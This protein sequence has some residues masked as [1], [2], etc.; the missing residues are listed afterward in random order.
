MH[1]NGRPN[2]V[3]GYQPKPIHILAKKMPNFSTYKQLLHFFCT[4]WQSV[5]FVDPYNW[6]RVILPLIINSFAM[7]FLSMTVSPL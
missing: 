3:R 5:H 1:R 2:G 6:F 7:D 4:F